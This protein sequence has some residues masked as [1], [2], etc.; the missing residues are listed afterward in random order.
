MKLVHQLILAVPV[1][2]T[3]TVLVPPEFVKVI[4]GATSVV[5]LDE[6]VIVEADDVSITSEYSASIFTVLLVEPVI[7][8]V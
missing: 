3:V 1:I 2:R 8:M 7:N 6:K 5:P 4:V